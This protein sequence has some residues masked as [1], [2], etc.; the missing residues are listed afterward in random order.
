MKRLKKM[1]GRLFELIGR[2][3]MRILP[4]HI[5]F[6]L[7]LSLVPIVTLVGFVASFFHFSI[8]DFANFIS[9]ALPKQ[10]ADIFLPF[11]QGKGMDM[12]VVIFMI[13]GF[14]LA[15]NG[16]HAII[17]AT[18][19]LY[20][21]EPN[22]YVSTR[23]KAIF[24]TIFL[25]GL[26]FFMLIILAFGN[27]ILQTILSYGFLEQL[28]DSI[29]LIFILL[30]WPIAFILTFFTIKLIYTLA[31]DK[32]IKSKYMTR[33]AVF[34]TLGWILVTAIY[35][36]YVSHFAN[37]DIFYGSLSN[38]IV[39]MIWIYIIS[40]ILVIGIAI[41]AETYESVEKIANYETKNLEH[42]K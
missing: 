42:S 26:F 16:A 5:A 2:P 23:I 36:Y 38:L 21:I 22:D 3:E 18:D 9:S 1:I 25:V 4:G 29:Y 8:A 30:K 24:L 17:V 6:F 41:N 32:N 13:L 37:Y 39:M 27:T 31:P 35:S 20:R 33:G 12:N 7:V 19:T 15:S 10:V 14:F 28:S 34:T 11:I 40:Y